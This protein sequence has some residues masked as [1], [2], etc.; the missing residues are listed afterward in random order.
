L[1]VN[2][3]LGYGIPIKFKLHFTSTCGFDGLAQV[4]QALHSAPGVLADD[5]E[6]H[7]HTTRHPFTQS[8]DKESFV[9]DFY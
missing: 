9:L 5:Q 3:I 1:G 8:E 7:T 2:R 4:K 6:V